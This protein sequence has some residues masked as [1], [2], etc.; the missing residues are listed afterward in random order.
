ML[1]QIITP[2]NLIRSISINK[3]KGEKLFKR[4]FS[5]RRGLR[6]SKSSKP[7][8]RKT[9]TENPILLLEHVEKDPEEKTTK[10]VD[11]EKPTPWDD[12]E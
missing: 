4:F 2:H 7:L 3:N 5:Y 11:E 10:L 8:I 6:T 12:Y 1:T 9:Y